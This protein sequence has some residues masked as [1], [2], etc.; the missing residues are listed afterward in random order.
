MQA[1]IKQY[2]VLMILTDGAISDLEDTICRIVDLSCML[3]SVIIIGVGDDDFSSMEAL[4]GDD[5]VL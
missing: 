1:G 5:G 2:N 4:D 3:C